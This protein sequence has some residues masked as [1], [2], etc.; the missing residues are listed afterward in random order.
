[1][2]IEGS[3]SGESNFAVWTLDKDLENNRLIFNEI[4][5]FKGATATGLSKRDS[6]S[7]Y[8]EVTADGP[9][10]I[11][12]KSLEKARKFKKTGTGQSVMKYTSGAKVW[13]IRHSGNSNFI[14]W[15]RC[16][17]G[18][19]QLVVN[20]IG[21]YSGRKKLLSGSCVLIVKSDGKWSLKR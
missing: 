9:W 5:S 4:G 1:M 6:K 12:I 17:N 20:V 21:K 7:K 19:S 8:L 16:T 15:Q 14:V 18:K 10:E 3:H 13:K 11:K 2:I